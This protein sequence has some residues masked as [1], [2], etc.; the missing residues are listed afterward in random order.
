VYEA[1][2]VDGVPFIAMRFVK[3]TDLGGL[4][5]ERGPLKTDLVRQVVEQVGSALDAAHAAGLVHRDIKPANIL[6][7]DDGGDPNQAHVYLTDFGL[8]KGRGES[9]LTQTGTWVGTVSY[10]APEQVEGRAV[11]GRADLYSLACVVY[12]ALTAHPPF[13]RDSDIATLY[14]HL[15][16][17]RPQPSQLRPGM[18]PAV[19]AVVAKGMARNASERYQSGS[20]LGRAL[21][22]A[23]QAPVASTQVGQPIPT[24]PGHPAPSQPGDPTLVEPSWPAAAPPISQPPTQ[25]PAG[26]LT[27]A[28]ST[29]PPGYHTPPPPTY[30]PPDSTQGPNR[31][32][33][34]RPPWLIPVGAVAAVLLVLL[35]LWV[36]GVFGGGGGG[37][38]ATTTDTPPSTTVDS[39]TLT[40]DT[41]VTTDITDTSTTDTSLTDTSLTDTTLTDTTLTD[42]TPTDTS[43]TD[44][45]PTD[46]VPTTPTDTTPLVVPALSLPYQSAAGPTVRYPAGWLLRNFP[47]RETGGTVYFEYVNVASATFR[48]APMYARLVFGSSG[49]YSFYDRNQLIGKARNS[50][51]NAFK[52]KTAFGGAFPINISGQP[53]YAENFV[54][55]VKKSYHGLGFAFAA[56][57]V[58]THRW[59]YGWAEYDTW[60]KSKVR[61][62]RVDIRR[63]TL[64]QIVSKIRW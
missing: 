14:A 32:G 27:Q 49:D 29:P 56:R 54:W 46:T 6:V 3:G 55:F 2:E 25:V 61:A 26:A 47:R 28:A 22:D 48:K 4:I 64:V 24:L 31:G 58:A 39:N 7:A 44:T 35:G 57:N 62:G 37:E 42:T 30:I 20:E 16:D 63:K 60:D 45:I 53:G 11:D 19:D 50:A 1:G 41:S 34:G 9:K 8:T 15:Q 33:G 5:M 51:K 36:G 12:E 21:R 38:A 59:I 23:L 43:L 13:E 10:I 52:W 40:T 18:P 17:D